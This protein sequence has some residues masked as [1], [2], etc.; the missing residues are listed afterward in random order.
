MKSALTSLLT[1]T[2]I[3]LAVQAQAQVFDALKLE[4]E[5]A[6]PIIWEDLGIPINSI[7]APAD[8][9][10][11]NQ[12]DINA[13][14]TQYM[15]NYSVT[16]AEANQVA[17][18]T[19]AVAAVC[20]SFRIALIDTITANNS[21]DVIA[22]TAAAA[23]PDAL[24]IQAGAP[25][26]SLVI[27]ADG[28]IG[29]GTGSPATQLH[30]YETAATNTSLLVEN[31]NASNTEVSLKNSAREWKMR[32]NTL[33][34]FVI[35]A[36]GDAGFELELNESGDLAI[37]GGISANDLVLKG[38]SH[39]LLDLESIDLGS[40]QLRLISD[41]VDNRRLVGRNSSGTTTQIQLGDNDIL[42]SGNTLDGTVNNFWAKIDSTGLV[43][44]G[45]LV[46]NNSGDPSLVT[47]TEDI[48]IIDNGPARITLEN[49]TALEDATNHQKWTINSNGSFRI[50]GG[51]DA[52]E[53]QLD[54]YG[55]LIIGGS[56]TTAG[57][58]CGGGCDAVFESDYSL[59]SIEDH[60]AAMWEKKYLPNVGPTIENQPINVSE[61]LGRMLNELETAHIYIAKLQVQIDEK[62]NTSK[63][64][65]DQLTKVIDKLEDRLNDLEQ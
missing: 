63:Q 44:Q 12:S 34:N 50:S 48:H 55:N 22:A 32:N 39:K 10:Q 23:S 29:V 52:A 42:L 37:E 64:Q 47:S 60:A 19:S 9:W 26:A 45:A 5:K 51:S 1:I 40:P 56:I 38:P 54:G 28:D 14:T 4:T 30:V 21:I 17:A 24:T 3:F 16:Q 61:K 15:Q 58:T 41:I 65:I 46:V 31:T 7:S 20:G 35:N 49:T 18:T 59:P 36:P 13:F 8:V 33:G 25:A 6:C 2:V 53:F 57:T 43:T 27:A 62:T 11:G